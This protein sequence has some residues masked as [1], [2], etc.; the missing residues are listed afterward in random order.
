MSLHEYKVSGEIIASG[1]P[2]YSL[3]MAAMITADTPNRAILRAG[4]PH[5][6]QEVQERYHSP[7]GLLDD[8]G[9]L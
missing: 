7:G 8:E 9:A 2:F 1:V 4:W 3:L 6:W 5:V